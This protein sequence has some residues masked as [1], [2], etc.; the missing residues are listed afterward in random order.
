MVKDGDWIGKVVVT[1]RSELI[2]V[3][4]LRHQ[5]WR[6]RFQPVCLRLRAFQACYRSEEG[7]SSMEMA[8]IGG[9][10]IDSNRL[11]L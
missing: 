7:L 9:M 10:V 11:L 6:K 4:E 3:L 2:N 5:R 8:R 1:M